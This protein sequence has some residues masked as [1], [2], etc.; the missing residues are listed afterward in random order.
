MNENKITH[1]KPPSSAEIVKFITDYG[2]NQR[3][4]SE[5]AGI[6]LRTMQRYVAGG[7]VMPL[8][9]WVYMRRNILQRRILVERGELKA[10]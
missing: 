5:C 8:Q 6:S 9:T 4:A 3:Q 1:D 2:A 7:R 10:I